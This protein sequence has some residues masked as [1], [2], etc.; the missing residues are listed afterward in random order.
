[1]DKPKIRLTPLNLVVATC[2]TYAI[3]CLL[4]YSSLDSGVSNVAKVL[5]TLA[6]AVIL[7]FTDIL[8]RRFIESTKWIWMIQG[9]FI[10][11]ITLMMMIFQTI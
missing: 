1:M 4:G 2:F 8:F 6:L 5:Y 11:L 7:F 10:I 3:Y 9:S